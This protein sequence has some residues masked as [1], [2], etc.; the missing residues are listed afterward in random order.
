[1]DDDR[2]VVVFEWVFLTAAAAAIAVS[3]MDYLVAR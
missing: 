3:A 1:M 2:I